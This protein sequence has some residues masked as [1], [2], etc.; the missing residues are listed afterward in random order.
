MVRTAGERD[1]IEGDPPTAH[2][3]E[4]IEMACEEIRVG[5]R[6]RISDAKNRD[7][8]SPATSPTT[9][10]TDPSAAGRHPSAPR[11]RDFWR[12]CSVHWYRR[13]RSACQKAHA[14]RCR[15]SHRTARHWGSGRRA[16][17]R[18][19][20]SA[21]L[22]LDVG[23][24]EGEMHAFRHR[25]FLSPLVAARQPG[26]DLDQRRLQRGVSAIRH[27]AWVFAYRYRIIDE[28][29]LRPNLAD[30]LTHRGGAL[31]KVGKPWSISAR[32]SRP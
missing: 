13:S 7:A 31:C 11:R 8:G 15:R 12:M 28:Y 3:A 29:L 26:I 14:R 19:D 21:P 32:S 17:H 2:V 22:H 10:A 23:E 1:D 20:P 27:E 18:A 6:R 25:P 4:R 9:S 16:M 30:A 24:V 5:A